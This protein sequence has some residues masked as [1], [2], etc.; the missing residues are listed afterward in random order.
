MEARVTQGTHHAVK[1][2]HQLLHGWS[3]IRTSKP[4]ANNNI[5]RDFVYEAG[6]AIKAHDETPGAGV[7]AQVKVVWTQSQFPVE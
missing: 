5:A 7:F 2:L 6:R 3:M 4:E 1:R